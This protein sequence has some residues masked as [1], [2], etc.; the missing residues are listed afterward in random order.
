[1][2]LYQSLVVIN[3]IDTRGRRR[4][5]GGEADPPVIKGKVVSKGEYRGKSENNVSQ[6]WRRVMDERV[7]MRGILRKAEGEI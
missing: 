7:R 6:K 3:I 5:P 2:T 1:M 4:R